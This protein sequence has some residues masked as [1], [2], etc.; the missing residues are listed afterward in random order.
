MSEIT[1]ESVT[2]YMRDNDICVDCHDKDVRR[3]VRELLQTL[4]PTQSYA[5]LY[6]RYDPN[7]FPY[8]GVSRRNTDWVL[9]R[10]PLSSIWTI[11]QF[12]QTFGRVETTLC[13]D[14][15]DVL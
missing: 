14:L 6:D 3:R 9:Y 11:D 5:F 8:A 2:Q 10:D 15:A 4:D 12:E 13:G 7:E 1:Y